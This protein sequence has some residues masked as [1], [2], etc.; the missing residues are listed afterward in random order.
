MKG[1]RDGAF[2]MKRWDGRTSAAAGALAAGERPGAAQ[3]PC[4]D[5]AASDPL[6]RLKTALAAFKVQAVLPLLRETAQLLSVERY[7][8]AADLTLKALEVDEENALAWRLL[9]I[10]RERAGDFTNSLRCYDRALALDPENADIAYDLG[11]LAFRMDMKGVAEQ[12]FRQ[13]LARRPD[14]AEGANNLA[15][16]LRDQMR[17][18]EAVETA[19]AAIYANPDH[20]LLWNTLATILTEQGEAEQSMTFFEEA[21]RL[22]PGFSKALYNRA[23]ARKMLGD[24]AG[25]VADCEAALEGVLSESEVAAMKF[26]RATMLL[27]SGDLA[28]G[29]DAYEVRFDPQHPDTVYFLVDRPLWRPQDDLAGK[30]LLLFGEQGLGDEVMFAN[31]VPDVLEALGPHG[32]L[33]LAVEPRLVPLFQRAFPQACVGAHSTG[34]V[35]HYSVRLAKFVEDVEGID[36]WACMGSPMRRFR[37]SVEAF[38]GRPAFL[39]ADPARVAHWR[40]VLATLGPLPKVGLV[41]KSLKLNSGRFRYY[42]PFEAW[43]PVLATPGVRLVNLQYGDCAAEL[44][45]ASGELGVEIWTPPGI[46][47]KD[48]LD[49]VAALCCALDLVAGTPNATTNIAAACGAPVW[50]ISTPGSWPELGT[51]HYPWYPTVRVF[52]SPGGARWGSTMAEIAQ[53]LAE[54]ARLACAA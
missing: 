31:V 2:G 42:S 21:L 35:D 45:Q 10:C 3:R 52:T 46:D 40:A 19:R 49:E 1:D 41:W 54:R 7:R 4:G 13:Y 8:E 23:N 50:M 51:D 12:L 26:A 30:S 20:P 53:A 25:G 15:C 18:G 33:T 9:A 43:R 17:F 6:G 27:A 44:A 29:W 28:R 37:A 14:S 32:R 47:L 24:P 5:L 48:D 22:D 11:H 16:A 34:R 39:K 36:F 38:P